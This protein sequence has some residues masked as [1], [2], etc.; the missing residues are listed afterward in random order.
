MKKMDMYGIRGKNLDWIKDYLSNRKQCVVAN[1]VVSEMKTVK[2]R[3]TARVCH[4]TTNVLVI[5]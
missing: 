1:D 4:G 3:V 2:C 5:C